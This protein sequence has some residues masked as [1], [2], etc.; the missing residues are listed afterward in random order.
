MHLQ[1]LG[2]HMVVVNKMGGVN[3]TYP[4]DNRVADP[5]A[6]LFNKATQSERT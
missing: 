2:G 3:F 1:I 5:L 4:F 6:V